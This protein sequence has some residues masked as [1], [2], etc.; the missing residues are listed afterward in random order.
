MV[1]SFDEAYHALTQ[2]PPAEQKP[3]LTLLVEKMATQALSTRLLSYPFIGLHDLLEEV[4][5]EECNKQFDIRSG[6]PYHQILYTWRV[7]HGDFKG[8][9]AVLHE[10]LLRIQ[11]AEAGIRDPDARNITDA[12]LALLNVMHCLDKDDAWVFSEKR[13]DGQVPEVGAPSGAAKRT[14]LE[15]GASA[16]RCRTVVRKE[17]VH[18]DY[19]SELE[20]M[21]VLAKGGFYLE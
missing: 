16:V 7:E 8:A 3:S 2:L 4:L 20:K 5:E 11:N 21:R 1:S 9:A 18:K 14:K 10:R 19:L 12:Q 13:T 6:P 15:G 17:D